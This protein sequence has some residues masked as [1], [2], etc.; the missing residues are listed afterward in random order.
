MLEEFFLNHPGVAVLDGDQLLGYMGW[1][2]IDGFRGTSR[3]AA[4]SVEWAHA[5]R[6]ENKTV[7]YRALYQAASSEWFNAGCDTHVV[8]FLAG[9]PVDERFWFWN[10]FG[11]IVVDCV[12]SMDPIP[13]S[14]RCRLTIR[15]ATIEDLSAVVEIEAEHW[16]HYLQPPIL[17]TSPSPDGINEFTE[18]FKNPDNSVWI[19]LDDSRIAGYIRCEK[20]SLGAAAILNDPRTVAITGAYTRPQYRGL[21]AAPALLNEAIAEYKR[22]GYQRCSVD[23]ESFN[24]E[25]AAF[26]VRYFTPVCYSVL[27]NPERGLVRN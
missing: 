8:T 10:G 13:I 26:W 1:F 7:I 22:R 6:S 23:F 24:P 25:A 20:S 3:K 16:R 19:A 9:D 12:R 15:R 11:L 27:R 17:M 18:F 2:L 21:G 4:L 5:T 14:G